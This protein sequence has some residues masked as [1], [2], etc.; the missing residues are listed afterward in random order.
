MLTAKDAERSTDINGAGIFTVCTSPMNDDRKCGWVQLTA[1]V[2]ME[3]AQEP[4]PISGIPFDSLQKDNDSA[5]STEWR[6]SQL[7]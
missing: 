7:T 5:P 2:K 4:N 3:H 6:V 1:K